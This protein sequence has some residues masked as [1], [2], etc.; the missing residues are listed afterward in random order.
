MFADQTRRRVGIKTIK[1]PGHF[2][3]LYGKNIHM[4]ISRYLKE[5]VRRDLEEKMVFIS[6]LRQVGKTTL[7]KMFLEKEEDC[8]YNWDRLTSI[9]SQPN[10]TVA[11][12]GA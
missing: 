6:G 2:F 7:A 12:V 1:T 10:N 8:Y 11:G 4:R 5:P 9:T 3:L